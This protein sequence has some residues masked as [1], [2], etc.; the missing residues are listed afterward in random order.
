MPW[1]EKEDMREKCDIEGKKRFGFWGWEKPFKYS[2]GEG[3]MGPRELPLASNNGRQWCLP[4]VVRGKLTIGEGSHW[5]GVN[6]VNGFEAAGW[7]AC[8]EGNGQVR[9]MK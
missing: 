6:D 7:L 9:P 2:L 8:C 3:G 1:L 5:V 4:L